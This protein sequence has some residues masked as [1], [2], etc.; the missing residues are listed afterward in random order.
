MK[1]DICGEE[2]EVCDCSD[3]LQ[4]CDKCLELWDYDIYDPRE[5]ALTIQERNPG[6]RNW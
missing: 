3:G 1:C 6:W 2:K 4:R 5:D